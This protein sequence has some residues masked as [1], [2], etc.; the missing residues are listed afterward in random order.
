MERLGQPEL[1]SQPLE[2]FLG[3]LRAQHDLRGVARREVQHEEDHHGDAEQHGDEEE[4]PPR[5][6]APHRAVLT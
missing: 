4:E 3:R 1:A 2:V 5:E 6:V